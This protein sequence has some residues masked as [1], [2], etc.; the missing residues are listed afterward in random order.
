MASKIYRNKKIGEYIRSGEVNCCI[1]GSNYA[2]VNHHLIGN[3]Y[4]GMGT[5]APD[6]LQMALSH[7]LHLELHN[8]GWKSFEDKY[9]RTQR[10]MCAE[11][12]A[13]LHADGVI[14]IMEIAFKHGFPDWML[15]EMEKIIYE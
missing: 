1:T 13:K 8:H 6:Y 2:V 4:S 7:D 10:S 15:D 12:I 9:G 3:G 14:D 5:K 11:T